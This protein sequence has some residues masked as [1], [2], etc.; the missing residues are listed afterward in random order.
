MTTAEIK[1][2]SMTSRLFLTLIVLVLTITVACE[3]GPDH[4]SPE[5]FLKSFV[6]TV[7]HGGEGQFPKFYLKS[8]DF[9]HGA[10]GS[11][12]AV[13]RFTGAVRQNF[14]RSCATLASVLKGKKATVDGI[15][16]N[17]NNPRV[18][19]FLKNV[20]KSYSDVTVRITAGSTPVFL[21][22]DELVQI[23]KQWRMTTFM[24]IIDEGKTILGERAI[25]IE[26][27]EN[28]EEEG[29]TEEVEK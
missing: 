4:S 11:E 10:E 7:Q 16:L 20:R 24:V 22:V 2:K 6:K 12:M 9:N 21:K 26:A 15:Q 19:G 29:E 17:N 28:E 13:N 14:M 8:S 23:D 18:V 25:K 1:S 27:P 5:A 3:Y